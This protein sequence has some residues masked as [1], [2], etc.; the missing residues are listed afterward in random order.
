MVLVSTC[1]RV[2]FMDDL[3][4]SKGAELSRGMWKDGSVQSLSNKQTE[5]SLPELG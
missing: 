1:E 4:K 3:R 5:K 2:S